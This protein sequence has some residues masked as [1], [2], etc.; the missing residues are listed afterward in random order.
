[1]KGFF[2][3]LGAV[4]CSPV[5]NDPADRSLKLPLAQPLMLWPVCIMLRHKTLQCDMIALPHPA[6]QHE[7]RLGARR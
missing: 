4:L 3:T 1:M 7:A 2:R 6:R 5:H